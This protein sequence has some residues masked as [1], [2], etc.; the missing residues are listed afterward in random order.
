MIIFFSALIALRVL[1]SNK[2][3]YFIP[4][5]FRICEGFLHKGYMYLGSPFNRYLRRIKYTKANK[6]DAKKKSA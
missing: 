3:K 4:P 2:I 6:A 1:D 5:F